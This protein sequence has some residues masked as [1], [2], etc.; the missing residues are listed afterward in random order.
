MLKKIQN[1]MKVSRQYPYNGLMGKFPL[2]DYMMLKLMPKLSFPGMSIVRFVKKYYKLNSDEEFRVRYY[3]SRIGF[4]ELWSSRERGDI[5]DIEHF[6]Q[7]HDKDIWRQAWLSKYGYMYKKKILN[8]EHVVRG[9]GRKIK[10]LDY[11]CGSGA[12]AHYLSVKG[13]NV[14]VADIPS[15]TLDFVRAEMADMLGNIIT[16][17]GFEDFGID[18]Y[19][20]ILTLDALEHTVAPLDITKRLMA[21][22]KSGGI[23][24]VSFP[25]ETDFSLAHTREAQEERPKVF[26]YLERSCKVII[27][28]SIYRK[29]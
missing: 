27:P 4:E 3:V 9:A 20:L 13:H 11:G 21:S 16:I 18:G 17:N 12:I 22:L 25:K 26:E 15:K 6:Y 5:K 23:F 29:L 8:V 10:I 1:L 2:A 14:D 28:E 19:D 7:E 24:Y